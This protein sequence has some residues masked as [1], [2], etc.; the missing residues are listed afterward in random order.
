MFCFSQPTPFSGAGASRSCGNHFLI[1]VLRSVFQPSLLLLCV[2]GGVRQG[3]GLV[4]AYNAKPYFAQYY[5]SEESVGV[6]LSWVPL[7]GGSIG[8]V[9]G[10]LLSDRL[11]RSRGQMARLWVL[12]ASQLLACPFLIGTV[13][14]P[15]NPWAFLCLLPAY[16]I[17]EVWIG[18]C[19]AV[20][21]ELVPSRVVPAAVAFFLFVINNIGGATPLLIPLLE[22]SLNLR[23]AL[24]LLFPGTYLLAGAL[25]AMVL[26]LMKCRQCCCPRKD[27]LQQETEQDLLLPDES[28]EEREVMESQETLV[29]VRKHRRSYMLN[30][31]L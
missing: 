11:V 26:V 3:G 2:A 7:V 10:G 18:V 17:G 16:M 29:V 19:L 12:T 15:P 1:E 14:L 4:W 27:M 6:Y 25:F 13:L 24:L 22:A 8:A 23:Y 9:F 21:I 28:I 30:C 5:C 31:I 20:V